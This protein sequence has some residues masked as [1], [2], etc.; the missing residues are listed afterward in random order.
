M[1]AELRAI[2]ATTKA[3]NEEAN[4][5]S[6]NIL[7]IIGESRLNHMSTRF[8][9][10]NGKTQDRHGVQLKFEDLMQMRND[11][12]RILSMVDPLDNRDRYSKQNFEI[13]DEMTRTSASHGR[14]EGEKTQECE[15]CCQ[16]HP[17]SSCGKIWE[18]PMEESQSC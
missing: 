4:F 7:R 1:Y 9:K 12:I 2:H 14:L 17:T 11:H 18:A 16:Q 10:K 15:I 13:W 3:T 8:W 5:D 6:N